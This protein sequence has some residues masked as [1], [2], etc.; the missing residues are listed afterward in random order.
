MMATDDT[1]LLRRFLRTIRV[2]THTALAEY[3]LA[4][5]RAGAAAPVR[6]QALAAKGA[7]RFRFPAAGIAAGDGLLAARLGR[8]ATGEPAALRLQAEGAAGLDAYAGRAGR[9]RFGPFGPEADVR[10]DRDGLAE[11]PLA[12][13]GLDEDDLA[14]FTIEMAATE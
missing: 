11:V 3:E 7:D 2:S 6:F 12:G 14:A 8:T 1:A 13:L 5:G 9:L 10:F 4:E